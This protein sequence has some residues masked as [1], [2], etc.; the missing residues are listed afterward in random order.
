MIE[1][2]AKREMTKPLSPELKALKIADKA[3]R[4]CPP[5]MWKANLEYL[6]DKYLWHPPEDVRKLK[7]SQADEG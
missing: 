5:R 2:E 3:M 7:D 1:K 4:I 6:I